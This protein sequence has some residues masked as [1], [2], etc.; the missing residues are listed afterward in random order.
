MDLGVF[1]C[2]SYHYGRVGDLGSFATLAQGHLPTHSTFALCPRRHFTFTIENLK[3]VKVE[4]DV[5]VSEGI[6]MRIMEGIAIIRH[7]MIN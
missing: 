6:K 5:S 3:V 7:G 4:D 1:G 2:K